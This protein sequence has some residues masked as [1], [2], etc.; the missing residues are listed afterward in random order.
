MRKLVFLLAL[1]L[2]FGCMRTR[3][4]PDM[5]A[6]QTRRGAECAKDCHKMHSWC[7]AGCVKGKN[8]RARRTCFSQCS[9]KL[10]DCY[11][12]CLVED[13]P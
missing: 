5:P 3:P 13:R 12:L 9:E 4:L 10:G 11:D 2:V 7:I 1:I 8:K 6:F